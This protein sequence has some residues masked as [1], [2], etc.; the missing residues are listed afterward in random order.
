M[1]LHRSSQTMPSPRKPAAAPL[2]GQPSPLTMKLQILGAVFVPMLALAIWLG[3][4]GFW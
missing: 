2:A 1:A 4:Q 3:R